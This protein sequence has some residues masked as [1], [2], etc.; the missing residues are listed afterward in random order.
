M[1]DWRPFV[2][3]EL[4]DHLDSLPLN[5][6]ISPAYRKENRQLAHPKSFRY[7]RHSYL[8]TNGRP[9][10]FLFLCGKGVSNIL[11]SLDIFEQVNKRELRLDI[12]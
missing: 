12:L 4:L 2:N 1:W 7:L 6:S 10:F 9:P 3:Q 8:F 11:K 5:N